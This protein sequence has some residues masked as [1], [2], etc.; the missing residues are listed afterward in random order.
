MKP[1][2]LKA[3]VRQGLRR[4]RPRSSQII[5]PTMTII[6]NIRSGMDLQMVSGDL[7]DRLMY[8]IILGNWE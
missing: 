6:Y 8:G 1:I 2:Q 5:Y 4:F 7:Q 3:R